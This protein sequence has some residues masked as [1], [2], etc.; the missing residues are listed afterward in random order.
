[1]AN[2]RV[3]LD[4]RSQ[5]LDGS[6]PVKLSLSHKGIT[7]YIGLD[8]AVKPEQWDK[9]QV[10]GLQVIG[11][12]K[13]SV[14]NKIINNRLILANN[15]ILTLSSLGKLSG[16]DHVTLKRLIEYGPDA[17][18]IDKKVNSY[19]LS[20]HFE[21]YISNCRAKGTADMYRVTLG[22]LNK[23]DTGVTFDQINLSWLKSF[24]TFLSPSCSTNTRAIDMRN[25][26]A[27]FNDAINEDLVPLNLYP[28]R[29]FKIKKEKTIKQYLSIDQIKQ[30]RDYPVQE[31]QERYQD[32][33]MLIFYLIGINTVD[34]LHLKH[35]DYRNGRIEYIRAKTGREYSIE[36]LPEA[37]LLIEKYKGVNYLIDV[38]DHYTYYKD[39][40]SRFNR[41]LKEIGTLEWVANGAKE[42]KFI[43]KNKK[44]VT[45]LFPGL[46]IYTARRSWAT[47]ASGLDIP[48]DTIAAA[49]GHGGNTVTDLYINFDLKKVDGANRD[50]LAAI[51]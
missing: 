29:K 1:M 40:S 10:D 2:V 38:M 17:E 49:L 15:T 26:R 46:M 43:K 44:K 25:I 45:P 4:T 48:K 51:G 34:L 9:L 19:T 21:R 27:V 28:F 39:F 47:I 12:P 11:H 18:P 24:D 35:K 33:F 37:H 30:F 20:N 31:H 36:V 42:E 22:K 5:R 6:Y 23:F 16:V 3:I 7:S 13:A 32:L 8:I 41:N 14:Y 50:V